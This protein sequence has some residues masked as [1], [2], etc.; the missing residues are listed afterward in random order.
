MIPATC[1]TILRSLCLLTVI[2]SMT[3]CKVA[4]DAKAGAA[5]MTTT[6]ADLSAYYATLAQTMKNTIALEQLQHGLLG[7][8]FEAQDRAQ[9]DDT[10]HEL[11]KRSDMAQSLARLAASMS[12]LTSLTVSSDV[13]TAASNL[14][15]ELIK[16]KALPTGS[17]IPDAVGK[18]SNILLQW[19]L[20]KKEKEAARAMDET[21]AALLALYTTEQP[22]YDSIS[23]THIA[24]AAQLATVLAD[25]EAVDPASLILPA[26]K[27]L[28]LTPLPANAALRTTLKPL[29]AEHIQAAA[30]DATQQQEAASAAMLD[31]LKEMS[32]R[33]HLLATEKPMPMRGAP[34]SLKV[35]ESWVAAA[36]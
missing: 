36:I 27:P 3:A 5:Q 32:S 20:Q 24:L 22:A 17:P 12:T 4:E 14:G 11:Q 15:N 13:S 9:L 16:I 19:I 2:A 25:R 7:V 31:S 21:L 6:A 18:A 29:A 1:K 34:F 23:R 8:P 35:V 33:I 28:G 30:K 10:L 26:L